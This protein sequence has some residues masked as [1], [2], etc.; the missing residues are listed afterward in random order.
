MLWPGCHVVYR[1]VGKSGTDFDTSRKNISP[2]DIQLS[3]RL[4]NFLTTCRGDHSR[5][6]RA[7]LNSNTINSTAP[8]TEFYIDYEEGSRSRG[9]QRIHFA[10]ELTVP[11]PANSF[12]GLSH[13]DFQL[14]CFFR[15]IL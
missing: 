10:F 14:S 5:I 4:L 11:I 2:K 3:H 7:Y 12:Y 9:F 13:K 1:T 15:N 8:G 6:Y